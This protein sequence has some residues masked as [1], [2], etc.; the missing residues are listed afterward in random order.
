MAKVKKAQF[1]ELLKAVGKSVEKYSAK[2]AAEASKRAATKAAN[3]NAYK[4]MR[5]L[6]RFERGIIKTPLSKADREIAIK[7]RETPQGQQFKRDRE[8]SMKE[9][10]RMNA[11]NSA[12]TKAV[13]AERAKA[14]NEIDKKQKNLKI[15]KSGGVAKKK[16]QA[17]GV[18]YKKVK[19]PMVD[20]R[21]AWT[22]VQERTIRGKSKKK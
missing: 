7:H 11:E 9:I 21:G 1:G 10:D 8:A 22:K 12:R 5:K 20:P 4:Q 14:Y 16:M 13:N 2:S 17:G 3:D 19:A 15:Y 18:A 6:D